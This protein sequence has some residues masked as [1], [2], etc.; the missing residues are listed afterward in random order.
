VDL[1]LHQIDV[2]TAFLNGELEEE[3]YTEQ[4]EGFVSKGRAQSMQAQK[5]NIWS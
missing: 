4:L 2:K 1:E 5:I 3:M